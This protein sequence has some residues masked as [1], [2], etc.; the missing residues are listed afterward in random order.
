MKELAPIFRRVTQ[1]VQELGREVVDGVKQIRG[2]AV[3]ATTSLKQDV[4]E[5]RSEVKAVKEELAR[6]ADLGI[7]GG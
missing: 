7:G 1:A 4:L 2:A 5:L 6:A 3:R